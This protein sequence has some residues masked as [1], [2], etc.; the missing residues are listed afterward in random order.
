ML[1]TEA[2][3]PIARSSEA[4]T[5]EC[6]NP[7]FSLDL[8]YLSINRLGMKA[9]FLPVGRDDAGLRT[10]VSGLVCCISV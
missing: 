9:H 6:L 4:G 2:S 7:F 5:S 1:L 3:T 8:V 10:G